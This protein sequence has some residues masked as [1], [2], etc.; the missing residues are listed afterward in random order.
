MEEDGGGGAGSSARGHLG[1]HGRHCP[2]AG[3][4][5]LRHDRR[6]AVDAATLDPPTVARARRGHGG[7]AGK[8][9]DPRGPPAASPGEGQPP[10]GAGGRRHSRSWR[11]RPARTGGAEGGAAVPVSAS[12]PGTP[13]SGFPSPA[14]RVPAPPPPP[15]LPPASPPSPSDRIPRAEAAAPLHHAHTRTRQRGAHWDSREPVA[16]S[17]QRIP[18][19]GGAIRQGKGQARIENGGGEEGQTEQS[20]GGEGACGV[21][22]AARPDPSRRLAGCVPAATPK[23]TPPGRPRDRWSVGCT[24]G[25]GTGGRVQRPRS[26]ETRRGGTLVARRP[27]GALTRLPRLAVLDGGGC[28]SCRRARR[29]AAALTNHRS[30]GA[31]ARAGSGPP[32]AACRQPI[33]H[34]TAARTHA[35]R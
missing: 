28:A 33:G 15:A 12:A 1:S 29:R 31:P 5:R 7:S 13:Q 9:V 23:R 22:T 34:A 21:E 27:P 6:V 35:G 25:G 4:R 18:D 2:G 32:V 8:E 16:R 30:R 24:R 3:R 20:R 17:A 19:R 10:A 26:V 14:P 11:V